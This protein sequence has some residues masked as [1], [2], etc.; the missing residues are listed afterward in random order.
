M[1]ACTYDDF[2]RVLQDAHALP[3]PAE[4]HG[5]LA[6]ALCSSVEYGLTDW[7]REILP[8]ENAENE[9][10]QSDVLQSAYNTMV[11]TLVGSDS[12]FAPLLPDDEA[13]LNERTLALSQWVQGFLYGIGSGVTGDPARV[14]PEAAEIVSDFVEIAHGVDADDDS[15]ES[16]VAFAEIVEFVRVGVQLLFVELAP[17]RGQEAAPGAASIH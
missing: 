17:A 11:R 1:L 10:L 3:E 6:G 8:D 13:E 5:T 16:E 9:A 12:D 2:A 15:E 7:L 4:A 14:S